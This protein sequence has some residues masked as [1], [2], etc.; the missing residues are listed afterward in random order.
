MRTLLIRSPHGHLPPVIDVRIQI[1]NY[2]TKAY[3]LECLTSLLPTVGDGKLAYSIALLDNASGDDLSDIPHLFPT[4]PVEIH[5]GTTNVGFGAGHNLLAKG[6]DARFLLL[7]NPDT[8]FVEAH[9]TTRLVQRAMDDDAQVVGP[10]LVATD[11]KTQPWDHGEL[12]GWLARSAMRTGNSFWRPQTVPTSAAWIAGAACL[13]E[14]RW[15]DK[16]GGFDERFFLYKEDEELCLRLRDLGGSVVYD[17]TISVM[18]HCGVVA[19]K[20]EHLATSTSV[21]LEKHFRHRP[22]FALLRLLNRVL[23]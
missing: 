13:F 14:K 7:L 21:F 11:G 15:F 4:L 8:R 20:S 23:R 18:H 6:G 1:V 9:T 5:H 12:R 17:P 3:L 10:R 2:E 22:G 16:L 19:R